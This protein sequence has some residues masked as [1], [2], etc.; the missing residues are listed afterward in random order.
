MQALLLATAAVL[1]T[2]G[3]SSADLSCGGVG[4]ISDCLSS[5]ENAGSTSQLWTY[6]KQANSSDTDG[7][8]LFSDIS[9]NSTAYTL[10]A[11]NNSA[12]TALTA[13]ETSAYTSNLDL[14]LQ[15]LAVN[16]T[17][18]LA[19]LQ[20]KA[21]FALTSLAGSTQLIL[22]TTANNVTVLNDDDTCEVLS[23]SPT[24]AGSVCLVDC[25]L[26]PTVGLGTIA[27]IGI[28]VAGI[29]AAC[30]IV[31]CLFN[32]FRKDGDSGDDADGS[33]PYQSVED[34]E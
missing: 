10:F 21:S 33:A 5:A 14:S 3:M 20:A 6:F 25:V 26:A 30:L 11:I 23:C 9:K 32:I 2:V 7:F 27:I 18:S 24:L 12:Y 19:D 8:S 15:Y 28:V 29:A 1:C 22:V 17:Y 34:G 13:A 31:A 4:S 16:Q